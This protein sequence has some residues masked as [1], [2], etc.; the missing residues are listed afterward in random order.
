[1][2]GASNK[3]YRIRLLTILLFFGALFV[4]LITRGFHLQVMAGQRYKTLG[5][6]QHMDAPPLHPERGLIF[7][8]N[9]EKLAASLL[10]DSIFANPAKIQNHDAAA[11]KLAAVLQVKKTAILQ[12]M[13]KG[14]HF[15]WIARM[16]S[17]AQAQRVKALDLDGIYFTQEPKRFYPNKDLAGQ[18]IGGRT[19][20]AEAEHHVGGGKALLERIHQQ[21]LVVAKGAN[22]V[23][24]SEQL[25]DEAAAHEAGRS[26]HEVPRRGCCAHHRSGLVVAVAFRRRE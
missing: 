9:G 6:Q 5:I 2:S 3:W 18:V 8:R 13:S 1:M 12:Q 10:V 22:R 21:F 24:A 26:G 14:K 16:V 4:I 23:A 19:D 7:D 17:P 15:C 25:G 11:A 20:A